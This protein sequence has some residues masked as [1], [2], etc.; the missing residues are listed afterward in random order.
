[1]NSC[2]IVLFLILSFMFLLSQQLKAQS[3][4]EIYFFDDFEDGN[5]DEW[6]L[7]K[8]WQVENENG[9]HILSGADAEWQFAFVGDDSW[10][11]YSVRSKI[12][13]IKGA[14]QLNYK[15]YGNQRYIVGINADMID[16]HKHSAGN[17]LMID[18]K[19]VSVG[20]NIWHTIELIGNNGHF[21]VLFDDNILFEYTDPD[22]FEYGKVAFENSNG[23][24]VHIDDVLIK[25]DPLPKPPILPDWVKVNGPRGGTG[26]DIDIHPDNPDIIYVS[27][28]AA[29]V[30]KSID[31]GETWFPMN[32][33]ITA[34]SGETQ[35]IIP[36]FCLTMDK[37]HNPD[38]IWVG[39]QYQNGV[40][41][42]TNGGEEWIKKE[43]GIPSF[44]R[45]EFRSFSIDPKNPDIVYCGGN[46]SPNPVDF[47]RVRGFILKT[48]DGG[49]H[50]E[51]I[52]DI[53]NLVRWIRIHPENT[54]IIYA[55]TGIF[56]RLEYEKLGVLK[57]TDGGST[58]VQINNGIN[59][60]AAI[61]GLAMH[62]QNPDILYACTGK[63]QP[64]FDLPEDN[65]GAIYKTV[66]AGQNWEEIY[67]GIE[68]N[69]FTTLNIDQ[70][71]PDII[72]AT[73]DDYFVKSEDGGLSWVET[74]NGPPDD[75]AGGPIDIENH[76]DNPETIF[77]DAYAGGVFKSKD[78]GETWEDASSGYSGAQAYDISFL[79]TDIPSSIITA[80]HNGIYKSDDGGASWKAYN[81]PRPGTPFSL[82]VNPVNQNEM[83]IG[84]R[85][86][87]AIR[88]STDCGV[89]W[90]DVLSHG[91]T[92]RV[93][94]EKT[95]N[96][97]IYSPSNPD[98]IYA[99]V[100]IGPHEIGLSV[101]KGPGVYK[102]IDGG[103]TWVEKNNGLEVSYRN[104]MSIAV[105]PQNADIVFI[106]TLQD[107]IY[108]T[109]D[110]G[111]N[112]FLQSNGLTATNIQA[113]A[114]DP[115]HPDTIYA[116]GSEGIGILRSTNGGELWEEIN[117]GVTVQCPAYLLPVG[118]VQLGGDNSENFQDMTVGVYSTSVP[119]TDISSIV[120][121]PS[122]TQIL[123]A[124]DKSA[125]VYTSND[126]GNN[127]FL[128]NEGLTN[129]QIEN[130]AISKDGKILYAAS[131][132][133]GVFRLALQN[134]TPSIVGLEPNNENT[135]SIQSGDSLKFEVFAYDMNS[136]TLE[137]RWS[138]DNKIIENQY[139]SSIVL[140]TSYLSIGNHNLS[141][142]I[143]DRD[144]SISITWVI[145]IED[146]TG[147][148]EKNNSRFPI[149]YDLKQNY[150]N[151]FNLNTT[152]AY[153]IPNVS[154]VQISI[155]NQRGQ[156]VRDILNNKKIPGYYTIDWDGRDN[157]GNIL[158]SGIYL[159]KIQIK[160]EN[161]SY[162]KTIKLILTK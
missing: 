8:G 86:G 151:P 6:S 42:T 131:N 67:T 54:D 83:I 55:S 154:K 121:D 51:Q 103:D 95:V 118:K 13:L 57:S 135:V 99:G 76:Y 33:G 101:K 128:I 85:H 14:M 138:I 79:N 64:F 136:D 19:E 16:F 56:D 129:R 82:A 133:G 116:G 10:G 47:C 110:G 23:G 102:S 81:N 66:N 149:S 7:G 40:F 63:W 105:H 36:I 45:P 108:K 27:D 107:G 75:C 120:I 38:V 97:I 93:E 30:H 137:Y 114:I 72:Y 11:N 111:D 20:Y 117:D 70:N 126:G 88:K 28:A 53:G 74:R 115:L 80:T 152:I 50:W 104:I 157:T 140:K 69:T 9:N 29:G 90:I 109:I 98:V 39:T 37:I 31:G 21:Q 122:N 94:D 89:T 125:G 162:Q 155:Y 65:Y 158:S 71:N 139:N 3:N 2:K 92:L 5:A 123:Y 78:G 58:W 160:N 68:G 34:R 106:G 146:P 144:T 143:A 59:N 150:P 113:L 100:S 127:W 17:E 15:I 61:T 148:N 18:R 46:Y 156:V 48:V 119:W 26:Y 77:I 25:G 22:P 49:D 134:Y 142:E 141:I 62:P 32:N 73:R 161:D 12:K 44:N 35:D 87:W 124:V 1:M 24:H 112:W 41:K 91:P 153:Q 96:E 4:W 130:L 52:L 159:C 132:G 145:L 84:D 147:L 43:N 60:I